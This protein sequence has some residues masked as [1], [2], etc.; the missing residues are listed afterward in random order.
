MAQNKVGGLSLDTSLVSQPEGTTR[1]V[2]N[3]LTETNEGI[4][5]RANEESNEACYTLPAGFSL[6]VRVYIGGETL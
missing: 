6:L 5:D 3:G 2:L 1:F 4:L